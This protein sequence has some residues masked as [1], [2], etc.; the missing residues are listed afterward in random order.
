MGITTP[1]A[2]SRD[3]FHYPAATRELAAPPKIKFASFLAPWREDYH[4]EAET[5]F[6]KVSQTRVT[7]ASVSRG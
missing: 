6:F 2:L 5:T 3:F 7:S 4:L 1:A